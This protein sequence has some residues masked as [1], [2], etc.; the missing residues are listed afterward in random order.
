M[1]FYGA[2]P[3][4]VPATTYPIRLP[5][6]P[7][8][9]STLRE[10]TTIVRRVIRGFDSNQLLEALRPGELEH[11]LLE[12]GAF[13]AR[14][15][16][17]ETS[18]SRLQ[19]VQYSHAVALR[20]AWPSEQ[21][22]ILFGLDLPDG[23]AVRGQPFP[24]GAI[25]IVEHG[26]IID[27]RFPARAAYAVLTI[28][29]QVLRSRTMEPDIVATRFGA[30][31]GMP[32]VVSEPAARRLKG[33]LSAVLGELEFVSGASQT[34]EFFAVLERDV[35]AAYVCALAA[36]EKPRGRGVSVLERRNRLV[37]KAESYVSAHLDESI[38]IDALCK[39]L[40]ASPRA[41]EYAFQGIYG[42]GAMRYLRTVRLNEVRKTLL[43]SGDPKTATVTAAAMEWGFWHL[44]EFAASYRRLFGET[45]SETLRLSASRKPLRAVLPAQ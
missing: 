39:E 20:G 5:Q 40:G 28:E 7:E 38:H 30:A 6:T 32:L 27:A 44:G 1:E 9:H 42:M 33:L 17:A 34:S 13:E 2:V 8:S 12:P 21:T 24:S 45:P 4:Q 43:R 10:P 41:L 26:A 36:T 3:R 31:A 19:V 22:A 23:A 29:R 18:A 37:Q 15:L 35:L 11:R 14:L 16:C 25:I